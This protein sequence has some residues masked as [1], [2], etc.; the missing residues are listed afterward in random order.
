M[1]FLDVTLQPRPKQKEQVV[2]EKPRYNWLFENNIN[3]GKE[4][5]DL[6]NPQEFKYSQWRTNG[7]LSNFRE[8]IFYANEMNTNYHLS[9]KLHYHF[10][11][12]SVKKAK[13]YGKKKTEEDEKRE[14]EAKKELEKIRLIQEYYKYN[15]TKAKSAL[16]VLTKEQFEII[17]KKLEKAE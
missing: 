16:K 6:D 9:D 2:V 8:N 10:L 11:F 5:I 7:S 15:I 14:K 13:R 1:T 4:L 17:K 3:Y 12:H